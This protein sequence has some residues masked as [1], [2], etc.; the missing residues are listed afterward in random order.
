MVGTALLFARLF[1]CGVF[2][3]AAAAKLADRS[4]SCEALA[5]FGVPRL[6]VWPVAVVLPI[7][8][9][10]V[11]CLLVPAVTARAGAI[12][13]L[14]LLVVFTA[15]VAIALL[16][17]RDPD[18]HCFGQLHSEPVG[19]ST[20]VRN[21]VLGVIAALVVVGHPLRGPGVGDLAALAGAALLAAVSLFAWQLFRQY[22]RVL[23]RVEA[24]ERE[25]AVQPRGLS[26]TQHGLAIGGAA[27]PLA[28]VDLRGEAVGLGD[29]LAPG[30]AVMLVFTDPNCGSCHALLPEIATWQREHGDELTI[31]LVSRGSAEDNRAAAAE[32]GI[33][34]MVLARD[35]DAAYSHVAEVTPSA[36]LLSRDGA[37]AAPVARGPAAIRG[38]FGGA[39]Q[40]DEVL[41][42]PAIG[43]PAPPL[44]LSD[45]S[46]APV[47]LPVVAGRDTFVLF[48]NPACGHCEHM[49][50]DLRSLEAEMPSDAPA[51]VLVSTGDV[52]TNRAQGLASTIALDPD[53]TARR[54]FGIR[55]TP[56]GV[57][58]DADG[59][60]ASTVAAGGPDVLE[61]LT[62]QGSLSARQT[63]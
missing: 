63:S 40:T 1:L 31:G 10:V 20:L 52:E 22:G 59:R 38:L 36:L 51:L 54:A 47:S 37:I 53:G 2:V 49:L 61:L 46:G 34:R 17:G 9:L 7:A 15:G 11:A 14:V 58:V 44:E 3:V 48:W 60:L 56:M 29:L 12:G 43:E 28:A 23:L 21:V 30:L 19:A 50:G 24:L 27:P 39:L 5:A 4:G 13:A 26:V 33:K 42:T 18:C 45:L 41:V 35:L 8:E 6:L 16:R 32:H 25:L 62:R 57:V 55:G